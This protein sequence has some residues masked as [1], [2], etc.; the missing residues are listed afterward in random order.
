M[1]FIAA[2]LAVADFTVE[3]NIRASAQLV[4]EQSYMK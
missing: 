3:K 2:A 1:K 4:P